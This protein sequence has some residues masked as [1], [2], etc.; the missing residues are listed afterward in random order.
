MPGAVY[1][2]GQSVELRTIERNDMEFLRDVINSPAVRQ[3]LS[4]TLPKNLKQE[5]DYF[6]EVV[7]SDDS[8]VNLLI[9]KESQPI[10][11]IGLHGIDSIDG[12]SEIGLFLAEDFWGKGYGT[13]ASRVMTELGFNQF[14][15]HRI[16]AHVIAGNESSKRVWEKLGYRHEAIEKEAAFHDGDFIDLHQFAILKPEWET[17]QKY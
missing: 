16:V 12:T 10:G 8:N 1:A 14:R 11:T 6:E 5:E 17:E 7:S 15:R 13:D 2:T 9:C 4:V 3:G